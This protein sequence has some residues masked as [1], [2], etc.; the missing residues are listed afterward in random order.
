MVALRLRIALACTALIFCAGC[1]GGLQGLSDPFATKAK[2]AQAAADG[3]P[4]QSINQVAYEEPADGSTPGVSIDDPSAQEEKSLWQ[5]TQETLSA[6]NL[7]K[8]FKAATGKAPDQKIAKD[9]YAS[10]HALFQEKKYGEA[11]DKFEEAAER[12]PDSLLEEDALYMQG[13]ALFF[14]DQYHA[15]RNAFD[16]LVKKYENSRHLDRVTAR[17]FAIGRFWDEKGHDHAM[18]APNFFDKTRPWFD[19]HGNGL[20]CYENIRLSDPTGPLADDAL[21]AQSTAY[22]I[23]ERFED[24]AYHY[25]LLRKDYSSSEHQEQAHLLG[26]QSYMNAYQGPQ[27]DPTPLTKAEK[28]ADHTLKNYGGSM[29]EERPRLYQA[30]EAIRAQ[31]AE[32]EYDL[33]EYYRRLDYNRAASA[34]YANVLKEYPETKFADLA[35]QR[36]AEIQNLPPEPPDHF[37]WLTKWLAREKV[38]YRDQP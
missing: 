22:F 30:Q 18:L 32:R 12:W 10:G 3:R 17:Q 2:A 26:L 20:K 14:D 4:G 29:P 15:A 25:E 37:P 21:M 34:H 11:A 38:S 6:E 1:A 35:K 36:L 23:D 13:E 5:K 16:T 7:K 8:Q 19:T 9:A 27:Y 24:A 31:I 33:G 28:L